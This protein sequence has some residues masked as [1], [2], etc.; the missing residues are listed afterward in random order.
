MSDT[1]SLGEHNPSL[2]SSSSPTQIKLTLRLLLLALLMVVGAIDASA[3]ECVE[4]FAVRA[5]TGKIKLTWSD[6]LGTTQYDV[7]RGNAFNGP[8]KQIATTQSA[9]F[10]T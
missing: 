1:C 3:N 10:S 4:D 2:T 5:K 9:F 7:L 6:E 8:Y